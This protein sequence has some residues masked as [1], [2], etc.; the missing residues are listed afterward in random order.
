MLK[1]RIILLLSVFAM[2]ILYSC[3]NPKP[4]CGTKRQ[5]SKKYKKLQSNPNFKM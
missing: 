1:T 3:S 2:G 5:K 4:A